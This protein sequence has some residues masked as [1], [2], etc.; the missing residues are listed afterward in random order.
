[1]SANAFLSG[2]TG[3][4]GAMSNVMNYRDQRQE[5]QQ[6]LNDQQ[7]QRNISTLM[8]IDQSF[9]DDTEKHQQWRND[10][11]QSINQNKNFRS[12]L[13]LEHSGANVTGFETTANGF[14]PVITY[15]GDDGNDVTRPVQM[16]DSGKSLVIPH[17]DF[18]QALG[19]QTYMLDCATRIGVQLLGAG[20]SLPEKPETVSQEMVNGVMVNRSNRT[21]KITSAGVGGTGNSR[22]G[23][24]S[25]SGSGT[26]AN[27]RTLLK[28][29]EDGHQVQY[30]MEDGHVIRTVW[31]LADKDGNFQDPSR[32]DVT[33]KWNNIRRTG[34]VRGAMGVDGGGDGGGNLLAIDTRPFYEGGPGMD[35]NKPVSEKV[36]PSDNKP[37][38]RPPRQQSPVMSPSHG[39]GVYKV[40]QDAKGRAAEGWSDAFDQAAEFASK[41][42]QISN[43]GRDNMRN[44]R[45][46]YGGMVDQAAPNDPPENKSM[47]ASSETGKSQVEIAYDEAERILKEGDENELIDYFRS[48]DDS[49]VRKVQQM[50]I[51]ARKIV[52]KEA[53]A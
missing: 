7:L 8:H 34:N 23:S 37:R 5:R 2:F 16:E 31:P 10:V 46:S 39:Y 19:S 43:A 11:F 20:G 52:D 36:E 14:I 6:Q 38:E 25:S 48:L 22:S 32:S 42:K 47:G 28:R 9:G 41:Q 18:F 35:E 12:A 27:P 50:R 49:V 3:G 29:D 44:A 45:T 40:P 51:R 17:Q 21:G 4:M 13:E 30:T 33:D 1:M 53:H 15:K 24:G 26:A